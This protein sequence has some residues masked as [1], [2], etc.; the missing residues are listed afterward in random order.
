MQSPDPSSLIYLLHWMVG[1]HKLNIIHNVSKQELHKHFNLNYLL[2]Q[3]LVPWRKIQWKQ[4]SLRIHH[5]ILIRIFT[6][7]YQALYFKN[8]LHHYFLHIEAVCSIPIWCS[9]LAT[10]YLSR[11]NLFKGTWKVCE[12]PVVVFIHITTTGSSTRD[13]QLRKM[14]FDLVNLRDAIPKWAN[15]ALCVITGADT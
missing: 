9:R 4:L 12:A 7:I 11:W 1:N 14:L 10:V 6:K 8:H 15:I 5:R 2:P 3:D 13:S